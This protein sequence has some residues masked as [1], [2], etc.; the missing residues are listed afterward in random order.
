MYLCGRWRYSQRN[1]VYAK[2]VGVLFIRRMFQIGDVERIH[3][4]TFGVLFTWMQ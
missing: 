4:Y 2:R 1:F 3:E